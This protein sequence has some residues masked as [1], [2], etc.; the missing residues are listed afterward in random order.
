MLKFKV[1]SVMHELKYLQ[2]QEKSHIFP[3]H[4]EV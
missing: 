4:F 1:S 2:Q 3:I